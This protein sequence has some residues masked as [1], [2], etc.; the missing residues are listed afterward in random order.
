[1]K[2]MNNRLRLFL[3]C[4]T[5]LF[6]ACSRVPSWVIPEKDMANLLY[7]VH[8]A[9]IQIE[10]DYTTFRDSAR[11]QELFNAVWQKH[12]VTK[13]EFDT[14]LVWYSANLEKYLSIYDQVSKRYTVMSDTLAALQRIKDE[15]DAKPKRLWE[16]DSVIILKPLRTENR[17]TFRV[18]TSSY[19]ALGDMYALSFLAL[20]VNGKLDPK[21]TFSW[22]GADTTIVSNSQITSNGI[23]TMYLKAVPG[24][25]TKSLSGSIRVPTKNEGTQLV[26]NNL[27][28]YKYRAGSHPE[29]K[30][31]EVVATDSIK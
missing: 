8:L 19:F 22:E 1:M 17:Y 15:Q 13:A 23:F 25:A 29:I 11:K 6:C 21:V 26:I 27:Y 16:K 4:A 10:N 9:E 7:D 5:I 2:Q 14:S 28:L 31:P 30:E 20:G 12:R 24:V 18:D 3:F